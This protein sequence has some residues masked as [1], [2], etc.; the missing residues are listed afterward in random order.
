MAF[1]FKT[2]QF[3]LARQVQLEHEVS[4]I[5]LSKKVDGLG[6]RETLS[7]TLKN[8]LKTGLSLP[9]DCCGTLEDA[10]RILKTRARLGYQHAFV[11]LPETETRPGCVTLLEKKTLT[12]GVNARLLDRCSGPELVFH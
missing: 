4:I 7:A 9:N 3:V 1:P 8:R 2:E 12:I 11:L 5:A 10:M 6:L